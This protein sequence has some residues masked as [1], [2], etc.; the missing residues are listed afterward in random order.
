[1]ISIPSKSGGETE[2]IAHQKFSNQS[3]FNTIDSFMISSEVPSRTI[4]EKKGAE[5][6]D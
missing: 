4:E 5:S 3:N 2:E 6:N 1:M